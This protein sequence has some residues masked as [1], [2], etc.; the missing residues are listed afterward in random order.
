MPESCMQNPVTLTMILDAIK[1]MR[2]EN[3]TESLRKIRKALH[4]EKVHKAA[5]SPKTPDRAAFDKVVA[6]FG[7]AVTDLMMRVHS[8]VV[9]G[10]KID[11]CL[12]NEV[13][14]F[15]YTVC[16]T[17]SPMFG[18]YTRHFNL[19]RGLARMNNPMEAHIEAIRVVREY[20]DGKYA[21]EY[22]LRTDSM[23]KY[24]LE[25]CPDEPS[26]RVWKYV[27]G[28]YAQAILNYWHETSGYY[29]KHYNK[30]GSAYWTI[31]WDRCQ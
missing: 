23:N 12:V 19:S 2:T 25:R 15:L 26:D 9:T 21:R 14:R 10:Q 27:Y 20:I 7:R 31:R 22:Y 28:L 29:E 4:A 3:D 6:E 17:Q 16:G 30:D 18:R 11:T 13:C 24:L 8:A 1:M 5:P